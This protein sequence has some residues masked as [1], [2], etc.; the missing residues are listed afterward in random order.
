MYRLLYIMLFL[1]FPLQAD[2]VYKS[3]D[4]EGN[5]TYSAEPPADAERIETLDT[6]SE[7][8]SAE[9]EAAQEREKK[10]EGA[11]DAME[12]PDDVQKA[13]STSESVGAPAVGGGAVVAGPGVRRG[14]YAEGANT[15]PGARTSHGAR[16]AHGAPTAGH[17]HRP[18]RR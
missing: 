5:V 2:E 13:P 9:V 4:E 7:P 18:G 11:L 3:V 17:P 14:T 15:A 10:L 16:T 8:S 1:V 12:Q 6:G